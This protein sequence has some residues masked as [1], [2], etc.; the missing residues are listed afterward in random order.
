MADEVNDKN[1]GARLVVG[2]LLAAVIAVGALAVVLLEGRAELD[3]DRRRAGARARLGATDLKSRRAEAY[4]AHL[5]LI[6]LKLPELD[7]QQRMNLALGS[8]VL[9]E[10]AVAAG[11]DE[12]AH[13][14]AVDELLE[15]GRRVGA[16]SRDEIEELVAR[17]RR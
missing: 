12:E 14:R 5:E 10:L 9:D 13:Q 4:P 1:G 8:V 11:L 6:R 7:E 2:A 16:V 3:L 17:A 15:Q